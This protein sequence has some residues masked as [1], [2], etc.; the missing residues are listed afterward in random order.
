MPAPIVLPMAIAD[1]GLDPA[2]LTQQ[3]A[4]Y[5]RLGAR[6]MV[7]RRSPVALTVDFTAEP[8]RDLLDTTVEVERGCC[9][10][11]TLDYDELAWRLTVAVADP[12]RR[13]ALDAIQA[14]LGDS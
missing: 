9:S 7:T 4:R 13:N 14:A 6:A 5:R 1:C 12:E 8:D 2:A 10:F 3:L 11:F